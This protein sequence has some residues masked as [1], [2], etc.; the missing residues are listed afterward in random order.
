[1]RD[2]KHIFK[3]DDQN[4]TL[5]RKKT[6]KIIFKQKVIVRRLGKKRIRCLRCYAK[7]NNDN[8]YYDTSFKANRYNDISY[9]NT[10]YNDTSYNNT[11]YNDTSYN[12]TS[13]NDTS[14]NQTSY[15]DT[16]YDHTSYN[17]TIYNHNLKNVHPE[18]GAGIRTHVLL[19]MS[20]LS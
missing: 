10:D 14:Y 3:L 4:L 2:V 6:K 20:L 7:S 15:N 5:F 12:H 9:N 19:N 1:M 8:H 18:Y 13:Y 16:S 17:D 11:S